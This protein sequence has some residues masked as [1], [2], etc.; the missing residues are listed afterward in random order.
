MAETKTILVI[1]D[2]PD[3]RNFCRTV[4]ESR[5]Y[6]VAEAATGAEGL[7]QVAALE[8]D[9][10]VLDIMMEELDSGFKVAEK[11]ATAPRQVPVLMLSYI[12][13]ASARVFDTS[14]VPVKAMVNKPIQP[15]DLIRK[16]EKLL[17]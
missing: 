1:D 6:E 9:L 2:D 8:P 14:T 7:E 3:V 11:L 12:A 5:G 15:D 4:L 13:D 17:A 16:V 10:V